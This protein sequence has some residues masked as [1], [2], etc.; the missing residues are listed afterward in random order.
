MTS[1]YADVYFKTSIKDGTGNHAEPPEDVYAQLIELVESGILKGDDGLT[2]YVGSNNNW[3]IGDIDTGVL[4]RGTDGEDGYTPVKGVDYFTEEEI[5][6]I[7]N[8]VSGGAIGDFKAVVD[9]ET[10]TFNA[11]AENTLTGYNANAQ[12]KFETYN[13][14]AN[15]KFSDYNTNAETKFS[16]YTNNAEAKLSEY[17]KNDLDKTALYNTNADNKFTTYNE[18]AKTK[19]SEYNS[20]ATTKLS[21]YNQNDSDKTALY[22]A[23]AESKLDAYDSNA[24]AKLDLYNQNDSEKTEAYNSNA[25]AKLNAYNENAEQHT[26]DYN[27]NATEKLE[28][29]NSNHTEKVAEYNQNAE[30]K[31]AEFDSN[32]A[33]LR[34]QIAEKANVDGYYEEMTVGDAEQLISTQFVEDNEPYLFRSTGG[35][36]DVGNRAYLDKIVGGTV[37]WNQLVDTSTALLTTRAGVTLSRKENGKLFLS[38]TATREA[39]WCVAGSANLVVGHK[40]LSKRVAKNVPIRVDDTEI[41]T[42]AIVFSENLEVK[43]L[44]KP[45]DNTVYVP[46]RK[47]VTVNAEINPFII[48]LTQMFGST[49]ADYIYSLEQSQAGAGVAWFKKLFPKDYYPYNAGELLSVEGLESHD[50]VWFNQWDEEW[51]VGD[52]STSTGEDA[53]ATNRIRSKGFMPCL[54]NVQYCFT[55]S[56]GSLE[57]ALLPFFYDADK[58]FISV[59]SLSNVQNV[60]AT[61]QNCRYMRFKVSETYGTTYK[62]DIC[63]NLSDPSRN[64]EYEPYE[65]HS[66]P[67]DS[68]LTLRG[69]PKLDSSNNLY[70]DGDEYISDGKV[71]RKYGVYTIQTSNVSLNNNAY[72]NISYAEIVNLPNMLKSLDKQCVHSNFGVGERGYPLDDASNVGKLLVD[73]SVGRFWFGFAKGTT[74]EQMK[75]ALDGTTIV[76][77]LATPT[78][79]TAEPFQNIQIVDDFG[80]EEFVSTGIV[81]VGHKTRYPANLRDKLQ[82]LPDLASMDGTYLV[83]QTGKQMSL[84]H[85]P[86]VFPEVPTED[87][88]YTLK[89][90][91]T[92]GVATLQWVAE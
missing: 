62:N 73:S 64:G 74:E 37:A 3:W 66:Y 52:I 83:K 91:V 30:T 2:P 10:A 35:S 81:P 65:K 6:Q 90:V 50:T 13:A 51:E 4:A 89:T 36:S 48:D 19:F 80:T 68:S 78:T 56:D 61:P 8:E 60:Q 39:A 55:V 17:N 69:I 16:K 14:N 5:Q 41:G 44:T 42:P 15:S 75:S 88:T 79:E 32:A 33:A 45:A 67:L 53:T 31:T 40:Y 22:N 86:A 46:V 76:Y 20:N 70:Y 34:E 9:E 24:Q 43:T 87:G 27:R 26:S 29:Y 12:E 54:P 58:Q 82:H 18:N 7:Q 84:V 23:N 47:G 57:T 72:T 1:T 28:A 85:T 63:V 71:K 49:I 21:E 11:N 77:E 92:G 59:G 38:G 25:Q